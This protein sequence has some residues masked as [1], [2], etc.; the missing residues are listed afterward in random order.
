MAKKSSVEN[1]NRRKALVKKFARE[2]Q[3]EQ[4]ALWD[5]SVADYSADTAL[6]GLEAAY[7]REEN[8]EF[9]KA[10]RIGAPVKVEDGDAVIFMNFRADR[11]RELSRAFVETTGA[12][13]ADHAA[14]ILCADASASDRGRVAEKLPQCFGQPL[15]LDL[16]PS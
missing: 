8:D 16:V 5:K 2:A 14:T 7:A 9:V 10:T 15:S 1:N 4:R 13:L 12:T 11:A 6:A 3:L